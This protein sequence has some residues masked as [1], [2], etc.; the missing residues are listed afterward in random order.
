MTDRQGGRWWIKMGRGVVEGEGGAWEGRLCEEIEREG[1]DV[2]KPPTEV[3]ATAD[4][5]VHSLGHP[6][7]EKEGSRKPPEGWEMGA[8][9]GG[10]GMG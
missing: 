6:H 7:G 10:R 1:V 9:R 4:K 5:G 3:A 2:Q 8:E